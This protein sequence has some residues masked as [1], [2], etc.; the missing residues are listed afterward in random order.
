[1]PQ[2]YRDQGSAKCR[3][4][5]GNFLG[6]WPFFKPVCLG[7]MEGVAT[8]RNRLLNVKRCILGVGFSKLWVSIVSPCCRSLLVYRVLWPDLLVLLH[9]HHPDNL[10]LFS[11]E[12]PLH[13]RCAF[14]LLGCCRCQ[15]AKL[16]ITP[17]WVEMPY[18]PHLEVGR[19]R[20]N[21]VRRLTSHGRGGNGLVAWCL[22]LCLN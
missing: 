1:M 19:H 15:L 20:L 17:V 5:T 13:P 21:E 6:N 18:Y 4:R 16:P 22:A 3:R 8:Q 10:A 14:Y 12:Y 9:L 2:S 11:H 7:M